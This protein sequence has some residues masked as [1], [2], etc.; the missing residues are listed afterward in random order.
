MLVPSFKM[1]TIHLYYLCVGTQRADGKVGGEED[2]ETICLSSLD[3][4]TSNLYCS[5]A[6]G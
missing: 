2:V 6:S 3:L 1:Q 5:G 4:T